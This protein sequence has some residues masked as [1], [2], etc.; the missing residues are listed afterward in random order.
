VVEQI[1]VSEKVP[2][3]LFVT[4]A[5]GQ[6][7]HAVAEVFEKEK[8]YLGRIDKDDITSPDIVRKIR[9]FKPMSSCTRRP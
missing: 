6:L 7:G 1:E 9:E 5:D 2:M 3:R 4:G 8:L